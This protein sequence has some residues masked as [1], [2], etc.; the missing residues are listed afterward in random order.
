MKHLRGN[1]RGDWEMLKAAT[2]AVICNL[3]LHLATKAANGLVQ[4]LSHTLGCCPE[5]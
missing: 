4:L 5:Q 3:G 1:D 2:I